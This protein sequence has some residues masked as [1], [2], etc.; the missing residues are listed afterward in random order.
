MLAIGKDEK[1]E[2]VSEKNI[3]EILSN[4]PGKTEQKR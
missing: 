4:D 2:D 3:Q 1:R